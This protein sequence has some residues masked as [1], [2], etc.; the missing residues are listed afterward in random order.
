MLILIEQRFIKLCA[1]EV[2]WASVRS[3][4][5]YHSAPSGGLVFVFSVS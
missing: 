2:T 3:P 5:E 4:P 1:S